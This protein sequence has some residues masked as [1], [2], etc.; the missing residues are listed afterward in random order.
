MLFVSIVR[1]MCLESCETESIVKIRLVGL[2][3]HVHHILFYA[4][5]LL[6]TQHASGD[7]MR[8]ENGMKVSQSFSIYPC[9]H[10]PEEFN[11]ILHKRG[12]EKSFAPKFD[13][14]YQLIT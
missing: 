3:V 6:H 11:L 1:Y 10:N 14:I 2:F 5:L 8:L 9:P 7:G 13:L 4:L 12:F